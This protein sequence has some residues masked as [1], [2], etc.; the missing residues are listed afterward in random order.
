MQRGGVYRSEL[1]KAL[2][3][4]AGLGILVC[5]LHE[6]V[7]LIRNIHT[8]LHPPKSYWHWLWMSDKYIHTIRY[9]NCLWHRNLIDPF[10]LHNKFWRQKRDKKWY[11]SSGC[12]GE[13]AGCLAAWMPTT[14]PSSLEAVSSHHH[15]QQTYAS[16]RFSS[17][18]LAHPSFTLQKSS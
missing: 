7:P 18:H 15:H 17:S 16:F 13:V 8:Y 14:F 5:D 3:A 1:I 2:T 6:I 11:Q 10:T 9:G 4:W 12:L